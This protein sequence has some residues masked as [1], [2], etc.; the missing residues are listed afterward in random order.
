MVFTTRRRRL[1][2]LPI[3]KAGSTFFLN[4]LWRLDHGAPHPAPEDIHDEDALIRCWD[5]SEEE[6][7]SSGAGFTFVREPVGRLVSFYYDKV[8][9]EGPRAFGWL[10]GTLRDR[11][12]LDLSRSLSARQHSENLRRLL[13][14]IRDDREEKTPQKVDMHWREQFF[15]LRNTKSLGL[16]WFRLDR[17]REDAP[18]FLA[19]IAPDFGAAMDATGRINA[20]PRPFPLEDVVDLSLRRDIC[21]LYA[22]DLAFYE[23]TPPGG[24]A[25]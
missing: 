19:D 13:A 10:K 8:W 6:I 21:D 9:G 7:R 25:P 11:Y 4:V 17:A 24:L 1:F 16:R 20:A 23:Q 12:G 18:A 15:P 5:A 22:R 14:F 2:Y 3:Q